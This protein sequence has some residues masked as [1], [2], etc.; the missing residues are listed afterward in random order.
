MVSARRFLDR[1]RPVG[2]PG[3]V[4]P[5]GPATHRTRAAEQEL[6]P[7]F[8]ALAGA[9]RQADRIRADARTVAAAHRRMAQ[10]EADRIA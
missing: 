6:A 1:F 2:V 9:G 10:Q 5:A 3:G 7:V 8:D 4:L